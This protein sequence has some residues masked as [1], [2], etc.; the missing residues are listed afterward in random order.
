MKKSTIIK[1]SVSSLVLACG[2]ICVFTGCFKTTATTPIHIN[3][4]Q[5]NNYEG[6]INNW[7]SSVNNLHL[8]NQ[9]YQ[10][11]ILPRDDSKKMIQKLNDIIKNTNV[12][13]FANQAKCELKHKNSIIYI[14]TF[15]YIKFLNKFKISPTFS[16]K[17]SE[18]TINNKIKKF[19]NS[20]Y[21]DLNSIKQL[22]YLHS[23]KEF[24]NAHKKEFY[25]QG[26]TRN[27]KNYK[28]YQ[29]VLKG[30]K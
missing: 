17:D 7:N 8:D 1:I 6:F 25:K 14:P 20:K 12:K 16:E 15:E 10:T 5:K 4:V 11:M 19:T 13:T 30:C 21:V 2:V 27:I 24:F 18:E 29:E 9:L 3:K 26:F 22:V 28:Q 23:F